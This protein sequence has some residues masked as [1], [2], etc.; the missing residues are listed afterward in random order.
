MFERSYTQ[1][2][3]DNFEVRI[4]HIMLNGFRGAVDNFPLIDQQVSSRPVDNFGRGAHKSY[5]VKLVGEVADSLRITLST[6]V[7]PQGYPQR[8]DLNPLTVNRRKSQTVS[9]FVSH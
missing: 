3:V 2:V 4:M 7:Y 5:Y 9:T 1:E 6:V 8:R